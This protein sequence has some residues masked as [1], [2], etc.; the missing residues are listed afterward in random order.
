MTPALFFFLACF[1]IG[2]ALIMAALLTTPRH[3]AF[4]GCVLLA[5]ALLGPALEVLL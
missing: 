4:A 3:R 1:S 2:G 5:L